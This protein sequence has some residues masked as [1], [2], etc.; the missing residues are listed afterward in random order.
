MAAAVVV[1]IVVAVVVLGLFSGRA[2]Q[3][4]RP[5]PPRV[6]SARSPQTGADTASPV[7]SPGV[8]ES[9]TDRSAPAG[10][11]RRESGEETNGETAPRDEIDPL[12]ADVE[13]AI[14][15]ATDTTIPLAQRE[16]EIAALGRRGD[17]EAVR[18]LMAL[19]D[20]YIY[21][22]RAAV[23]ALAQINDPDAVAYLRKRMK[24]VK[25]HDVALLCEVIG[26][27]GRALGEKA[28]PDLAALLKATRKRDDGH[29][30]EIA[31]ACVRAVGDLK[32]PKT[33]PVLRDEIDYLLTRERMDL[34]YGSDIVQALGKTADAAAR[35]V[36]ISYADGLSA[37]VPPEPEPR[38]Y[39][40]EKIREARTAAGAL[41]R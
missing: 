6:E 35:P 32:T 18:V 26:A 1:V 23:K 40:L 4:A 13:R 39:F 20:R 16:K 12:P 2:P 22:N 10:R 27:T 11:N 28:I 36:L 19:A 29:A 17:K 21:L 3:D 25:T 38:A 8:E 34:T 31:R 24:D 15:R 5:A 37:K 30:I 14:A 7:T 41:P 33:I 9:S